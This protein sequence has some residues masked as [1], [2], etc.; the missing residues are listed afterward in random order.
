MKLTR[1]NKTECSWQFN[2]IK[3]KIIFYTFQNSGW[4]FPT[5]IKVNEIRTVLLGLIPPAGLKKKYLAHIKR[6]VQKC[7]FT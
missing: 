7:N 1:L 2:G 5:R 3:H 6:K 4:D